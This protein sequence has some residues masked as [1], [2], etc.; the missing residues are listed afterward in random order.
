MNNTI[1]ENPI[2]KSVK[3]SLAIGK[4]ELRIAVPFINGF[5]TS[6]LTPSN[7]RLFKRKRLLTRLD[8]RSITTFDLKTLRY[9]LDLGFE[10]RYDNCIHLKLYIIDDEAFLS[11]A[12]LTKGGF[13]DNIELT[14]WIDANEA[15]QCQDIF[16]RLWDQSQENVVSYQTIDANWDKYL[17]LRA[18]DPEN[19]AR[20][21]T[22]TPKSSP[23]NN[24]DL[25]A[26]LEEILRV[27]D[28][29]SHLLIWETKAN[30]QRNQV[31][32]LLLNGFDSQIFYAP[33]GNPGRHESLFHN[34]VYGSESK[35]A[36]TGL[37][38]HQMQ[39]AFGHPKFEQLIH[40]IYPEMRGLKPWDFETEGELESMLSGFGDFRI[41]EF[42]V[43]L[44]IRLVTF[45]YPNSLLPIFNLQH[46]EEI[47]EAFGH[48]PIAGNISAKIYG[49]NSFLIEAMK[50][51]PHTNTIK[52]RVAY[53]LLYAIRL[54]SEIR[55]GQT[56][57][58]CKDSTRKQ[59][60]KGYYDTS[61]KIL[62]KLKL[63]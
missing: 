25:E 59:C 16:D 31:K 12:N 38:E 57:Q 58:S 45:F 15:I 47:S 43:A 27:H 41:P 39:T 54:L 19:G 36:G 1:I 53:Q 10:I 61:H 49:Y 18:R 14:V 23:L 20:T 30:K 8:D 63:I 5:A 40:F 26:L 9:L 32:Q 42:K 2:T 35:L 13:E 56:L 55:K 21:V 11:S 4:E 29:F 52:S 17:V 24:I 7:T 37:R 46:L 34:F 51:L 44:P 50:T 33:L 3:Q 60:I 48:V 28:K 22:K 62:S 6:V